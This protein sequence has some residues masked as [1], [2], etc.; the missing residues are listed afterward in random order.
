MKNLRI[1]LVQSPLHWEN[2]TANLAMF[3]ELL[4]DLQG[5]TDII[6]LPEMFTTGFSMNTSLAEHPQLTT[7]RW[8]QQQAKHTQAVICGSYMV[9]EGD[10]FYNRFMWVEP[11]GEYASYDKKHLFSM[12]GENK[13]F[14]AGT[15][16]IIKELQG[17]K[18]CPLIC[19]D[20][21]FP[22]WSYNMANGEMKYDCL[23]YTANFPEARAGVWNTL[24]KAR[25]IENWSYCVGVNRIG[26]DGNEITYSGDSAVI[27]PKG[28]PI[29]EAKNLNI[30]QTVELD[31]QELQE[32]RQKFPAYLDARY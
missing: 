8:L 21:R 27:N 32:Y 7:F 11:S 31:W 9:K 4:W 2:P 23:I 1:T 12:A 17:W 16:L 18:I 10:K 29:F 25:A 5:K 3:E 15:Q 22:L 26:V 13:F 6:V 20:L 14:T 28:N 24:L 30:V 19:Y